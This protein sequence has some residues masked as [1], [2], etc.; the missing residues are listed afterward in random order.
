M[1][2]LIVHVQRFIPC[3]L[4]C[5]AARLKHVVCTHQLVLLLG[6]LLLTDS[7]H[8]TSVLRNARHSERRR[9]DS[10]LKPAPKVGDDQGLAEGEPKS[11]QE[12]IVGFG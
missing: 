10:L 8:A 7:E 3:G 5:E 11:W 4:K 12:K 6:S 2:T 9:H 1:V